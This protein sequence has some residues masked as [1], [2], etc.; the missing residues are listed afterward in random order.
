VFVGPKN[1]DLT[2]VKKMEGVSQAGSLRF[3]F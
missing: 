3:F 1:A 2:I